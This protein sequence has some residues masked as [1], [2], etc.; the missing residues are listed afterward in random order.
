MVL[1][2]RLTLNLQDSHAISFRWIKP[3][4]ISIISCEHKNLISASFS[5][6][7]S[8]ILVKAFKSPLN[9]V[10]LFASVVYSSSAAKLHCKLKKYIY[11]FH[12]LWYCTSSLSQYLISHY[13]CSCLLSFKILKN[14]NQYFFLNLRY[15]ELHRQSRP[16]K[17]QAATPT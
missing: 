13:Y 11:F 15:A 16:S 12:S 4:F 5:T 9:I 8:H 1:A 10:Q 14:E 7:N 17:S 3:F 6:T 2:T